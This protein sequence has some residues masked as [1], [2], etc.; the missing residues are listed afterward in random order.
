MARRC[1]SCDK[2][3]ITGYNYT[4][5]RSHW[6]PHNKRRWLP[7]LQSIKVR[8]AGTTKRMKVCTACIKAGKV[9]KAG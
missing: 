5:L 3:P 7:N 2:G 1:E 8:V 6:N 4:F 9:Q